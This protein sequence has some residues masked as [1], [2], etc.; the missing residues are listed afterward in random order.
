[1]RALRYEILRGV[2]A[3]GRKQIDMP[4]R[5]VRVATLLDEARFLENHELIHNHT[6]FIEER[7]FLCRLAYADQMTFELDDGC[8]RSTAARNKN[9][10]AYLYRSVARAS[11]QGSASRVQGGG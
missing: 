7:V 5:P 4:E 2:E 10:H 6:V 11:P 9:H 3:N 8:T 1:M